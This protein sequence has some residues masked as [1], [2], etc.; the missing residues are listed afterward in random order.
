MIYP[1]GSIYISFNSTNPGTFLG[2]TWEEFSGERFLLCCDTQHQSGQMGGE[3]THTLT[4]NEMPTHHHVITYPNAGGPDTATIG[5]CQNSGIN[6]SWGAEMCTTLSAGAGKS[7][8][9]MPPYI[10]CYAWK[11]TK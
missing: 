4:A 7:H 11:R 6:K 2:G 5:F 1:V 10:T 9:N 3:A 8:N